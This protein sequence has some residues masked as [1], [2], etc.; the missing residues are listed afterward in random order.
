MLRPLATALSFVRLPMPALQFGPAGTRYL[1]DRGLLRPLLD[2]PVARYRAVLVSTDVN[3]PIHGLFRRETLERIGPHH[4]HGSD[5]LVVAH[6]ALLGRFAYVPAPLFGYRIHEGS[7]VH[8]TR[9]E[10][11]ERDTG[12]CGAGSSI[13]GLRTLRRYLEAVVE[14]D[15]SPAQRLRAISATL[16]YATRPEVLHR[17]VLPS[18][19]NYWGWT[20]N[21]RKPQGGHRLSPNTTLGTTSDDRWAWLTKGKATKVW[22]QAESYG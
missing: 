9:E 19:D 17:L 3:A 10:W 1:F 7:T 13:D 8:L 20:G 4:I 11:I 21:L 22:A 5:R 14:A 16:G 2:D 18:V 15:L 12:E 6:A